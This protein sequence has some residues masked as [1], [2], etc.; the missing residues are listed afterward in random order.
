MNSIAERKQ[1]K[2]VVLE[3]LSSIIFHSSSLQYK[4]PHKISLFLR[5]WTS[6]Q[7]FGHTV[8]TSPAVVPTLN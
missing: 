6:G 3:S 2:L 1:I 4:L 5:L 7:S 8:G